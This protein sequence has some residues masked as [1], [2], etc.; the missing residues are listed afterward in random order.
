M[1]EPHSSPWEIWL[2]KWFIRLLIPAILINAC[3]LFIRIIEP[4][5]ALYATISRTIAETGDFIHLYVEGKDWLDKP[6]FPFWMAAFSMRIFGINSF[7]YKLPALLFWAAGGWYVYQMAKSLHGKSVAQLSVLIYVSAAHLVISNNDVRAEPYLTGLV[8]GAVYHFYKASRAK[9]G[10]HLLA[11]SFL[12]ACAVMTKGPFVLVTIGGGFIL[13]WIIGKEWEQFRSLRWWLALLLIGIFIIP[14]LYCLYV[15]FDLHPEKK[16]F[17][18]TGV[19]GIRFF[20]WDSQFGRFFNTGP[21]KGSGDPFFYFHT[22]LWAFL[23][24][25]LLLY[26]AV[27]RK[28]RWLTRRA[29]HGDAICLGAAVLSFAMFSLSS[30]QLPYYL[31]ILF[32][33]FCILTAEYLYGIRRRITVKA[34]SIVQGVIIFLLPVLLLTL[35]WFSHF[36]GWSF[37]MAALLVLSILPFFLFRGNVLLS[38]TGRSCWMALLTFLFINCYFYP[39]ILH[40]Q[41]GM[42]AADYM[43][44]EPGPSSPELSTARVVYLPEKGPV[45][46]SIEFYAPR[47]VRRLD[48][49][50][51][52]AVLRS[53]P[54]LFFM[55]S[56]FSDTLLRRGYQVRQV[57]TFPNFHVSQLTGEFLYYRTR[58]RSLEWFEL[59]WVSGARENDPEK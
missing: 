32:P 30:F 41:S 10:L 24:W 8:I 2:D 29:V 43:R 11:G 15:Q 16:I 45:N 23:P 4:D 18:R 59:A 33:F 57:K 35:C 38:A 36:S 55:P 7:A 22:L 54:A 5:G 19:S 52:P 12:A 44:R 58:Q 9:P 6:H 48:L 40:Y 49:D 28:F 50:T 27:F 56:R 34:V 26:A 20:F 21:I 31:N 3:G 53:G 14:E 47:S 17:H 37:M 13:D 51:L 25:S 39:A 1:I 46:Y 42:V